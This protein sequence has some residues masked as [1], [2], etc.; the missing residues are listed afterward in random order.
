MQRVTK[1]RTRVASLLVGVPLALAPCVAS[2]SA[3]AQVAPTAT[4]PR[5]YYFA[6][7]GYC[8]PMQPPVYAYSPPVYDT[9][10]PVYQPP[11]VVDGVAIGLGLG[12]LFGALSGDHEDHGDR[13]VYHERERRGR[14]GR[15]ERGRR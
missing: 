10:P 3:H 15:P 1:I 2:W 13:G 5:G 12:L 4:C 14:G 11:S 9:A 7:D 8:Y 6:R